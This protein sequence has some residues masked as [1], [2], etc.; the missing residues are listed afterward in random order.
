MQARAAT[1]TLRA[2]ASDALMPSSLSSPAS[3][4]FLLVLALG[5]L[6]VVAA[7]PR[8]ESGAAGGGLR[9]SGPPVRA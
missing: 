8:G 3:S 9:R 7:G 5:W 1:G 4:G 6:L 2:A